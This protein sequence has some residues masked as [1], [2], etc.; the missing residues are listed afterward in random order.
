MP[1]A[2]PSI[3]GLATTELGELHTF[4]VVGFRPLVGRP[5]FDYDAPLRWR[6]DVRASDPC[7]PQR[8]GRPR[9]H[10][11]YLR[12]DAASCGVDV[13]KGLAECASCISSRARWRRPCSARTK[14]CAGATSC[15]SG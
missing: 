8:R 1:C 12:D 14:S 15:D 5:W 9:E 2:T 7:G 6:G 3:R 4:S 10:L 13:L 11:A